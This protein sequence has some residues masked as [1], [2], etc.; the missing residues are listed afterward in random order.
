[1]NPRNTEDPSD[2]SVINYYKE[3]YKLIQNDSNEIIKK[4]I[5]LNHVLAPSRPRWDYFM[6]D[7]YK[8][9][10][11]ALEQLLADYIR[12]QHQDSKD[13]PT[14][15]ND[16]IKTAESGLIASQSD[17]GTGPMKTAEIYYRAEKQV[18]EQ[19]LSEAHN[20]HLNKPA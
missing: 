4:I 1:M 12:K 10:K 16:R 5:L 8:L 11:I 7:H 3:K 15:L 9:E 2:D 17:K 20:S 6:R 19:M 18:L 14:V 13:N